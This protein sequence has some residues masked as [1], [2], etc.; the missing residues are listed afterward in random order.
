MCVYNEYNQLDSLGIG[1]AKTNLLE[2]VKE[3]SF[4]RQTKRNYK[5]AEKF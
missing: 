2:K 4:S 1:R 5:L 3:G